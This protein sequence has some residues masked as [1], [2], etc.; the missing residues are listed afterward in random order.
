MGKS[1]YS[2]LIW[3]NVDVAA[4]RLQQKSKHGLMIKHFTDIQKLFHRQ[5]AHNPWLGLILATLLSTSHPRHY[6]FP[7]KNQKSSLLNQRCSLNI[8]KKNSTEEVS[9]GENISK[10]LKLILCCKIHLQIPP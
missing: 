4:I 8:N 2:T 3:N 9:K 10:H 5:V 6:S 1:G 7:L